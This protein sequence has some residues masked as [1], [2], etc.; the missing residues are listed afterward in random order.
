V[1]SNL[2]YF[3]N[4]T[5]SLIERKAKVKGIGFVIPVAWMPFKSPFSTL[6]SY[7]VVMSKNLVPD[8]TFTSMVVSF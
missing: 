1:L 6:I 3:G 7:F 8:L 4:Q 2:V 5:R